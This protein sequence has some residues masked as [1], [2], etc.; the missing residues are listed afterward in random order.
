[1]TPVNTGVKAQFVDDIRTFLIAAGDAD[2]AATL[3]L[4]DLSDHAADRTRGSGDDYRLT[5]HWSAD[6]EQGNVGRHS[7][8]AQNPQ[9]IRNWALL[10]VDLA[11]SFAIGDSE[12]LP[13]VVAKN[14]FSLDESRVVGLDD[15]ADG[16]ADHHLAKFCGLGIGSPGAH[17][18]AHVGVQRQVDSV[19]QE[20]AWGRLGQGRLLQGKVAFL[21]LAD[22]TVYQQNLSIHGARHGIL[23]G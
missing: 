8:H 1:R 17:A 15:L 13:T 11:H 3:D 10:G 7:W 22:R 14:Q 21:G 12:F 23:L 6:V 20:L 18:A 4:G 5:W 9:E 2:G 16:T 19:A